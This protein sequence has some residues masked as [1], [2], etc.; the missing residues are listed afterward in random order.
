[1]K[2]KRYQRRTK[3]VHSKYKRKQAVVIFGANWCPDCRILAGTL[4]L[5]S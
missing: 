3:K 4:K 5:P 1:M 2:E